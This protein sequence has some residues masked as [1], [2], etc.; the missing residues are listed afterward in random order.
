MNKVGR[1]LKFKSVQELEEKIE[2]YF[3]DRDDNNM[4]YNV[5]S[6][7]I[8]L[9][10]TRETLIDYEMKDQYSY[11]IKKAK[12]KILSWKEDQ[13]YRK[14]GQIAGIIFDLK[15]NYSDI[16]KDRVDHNHTGNTFPNKVQIEFVSPDENS[17]TE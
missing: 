11:T 13:L 3:K 14:S 6:L 9:D 16:Y 1:P 10:T 7:A 15:N 5:T 8:W 2:A 12:R 4:P 17:N